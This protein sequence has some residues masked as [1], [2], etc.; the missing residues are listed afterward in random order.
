MPDPPKSRFDEMVAREK[1]LLDEYNAM[2]KQVNGAKSRDEQKALKEKL[3]EIGKRLDAHRAELRKF[4][5]GSRAAAGKIQRAETDARRL[6]GGPVDVAFKQVLPAQNAPTQYGRTNPKEC[7][8][9]SFQ[10]AHVDPDAL[11]RLSPEALK[12]FQEGKH[13]EAAKKPIAD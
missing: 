2:V 7:F 6:G 10:L 4:Q 9:E 11:A 12:W 13:V 3:D 8:A 1:G 5:D